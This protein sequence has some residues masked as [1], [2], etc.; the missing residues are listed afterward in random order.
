MQRNNPGRK[1]SAQLACQSCLPDR[2]NAALGVGPRHPGLPPPGFPQEQSWSL[3]SLLSGPIL[4]SGSSQGHRDLRGGLALPGH[5][6]QATRR[7]TLPPTVPS[8]LACGI[9]TAPSST[10]LASRTAHNPRPLHPSLCSRRPC[11]GGRQ[12]EPSRASGGEPKGCEHR[13]TGEEWGA[14]P[15]LRPLIWQEGSDEKKEV[16][17]RDQGRR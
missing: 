8:A 10:S 15:K 1:V 6:Q 9:P 17:D 2:S 12:E 13:G 11:P 14:F 16:K 3:H 7:H 5:A 4:G